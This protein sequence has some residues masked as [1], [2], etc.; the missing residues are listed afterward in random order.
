[1]KVDENVFGEAARVINRPALLPA[2]TSH[3]KP[4]SNRSARELQIRRQTDGVGG[5]MGH[6]PEPERP[7]MPMAVDIKLEGGRLSAP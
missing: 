4:T 2:C 3:S 5:S 7:G 6:R 1:M